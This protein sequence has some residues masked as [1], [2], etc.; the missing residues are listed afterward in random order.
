[1]CANKRVQPICVPLPPAPSLDRDC[2]FGSSLVEGDSRRKGVAPT[3]AISA[4]SSLLT[5]RSYARDL[6]VNAGSAFRGRWSRSLSSP[7]PIERLPSPPR[8]MADFRSTLSYLGLHSLSPDSVISVERRSDGAPRTRRT[9]RPYAVF[10]CRQRFH[11]RCRFALSNADDPATPHLCRYQRFPSAVHHEFSSHSTLI[12][13][14]FRKPAPPRFP[15]SDSRV[16][17]MS[18]SL[19]SRQMTQ[20]GHEYALPNAPQS[21]RTSRWRISH[22]GLSILHFSSSRQ[23]T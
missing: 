9:H 10:S 8:E 14:R 11:P 7:P 13:T 22:V 2:R 16:F 23:C 15:S 20:F 18:A 5:K 6:S 3:C 21:Y 12:A 4:R 17:S 19:Q 1:M